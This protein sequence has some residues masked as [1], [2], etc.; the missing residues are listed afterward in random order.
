MHRTIER[1]AAM[2]VDLTEFWRVK[3]Q[4]GQPDPDVNAAFHLMQDRYFRAVWRAIQL[5]ETDADADMLVYIVGPS[6]LLEVARGHGP[7][8]S[9]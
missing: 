7:E 8:P 5:A 6:D 4:P 3:V 1:V 2:K 9:D